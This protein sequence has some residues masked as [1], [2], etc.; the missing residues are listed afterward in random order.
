MKSPHIFPALALL[1][2][3]AACEPGEDGINGYVE[4]EFVRVAP[5]SGGV[6]KTLFVARGD[7][8]AAGDSLF[9]LDLT[10]LEA[11][12]DAAQAEALQAEE[13]WRDLT[14]GSRAEE[15]DVIARQRAQAVAVLENA[16]KQFRR[17][18]ELVKADATSIKQRDQDKAAFESAAARVA[19]LEAQLQVAKLPERTDRVAAA[20]AAADAA[21]AA[22]GRAEKLL[23]EARPRA[24][25]A[26]QVEDTF[27]RPGEFV[28]PGAPVVSLLP[29]GNVKVR[30]FAPQKL[31]PRLRPGRKVTVICDGC[32]APVTAAVSFI[33]N[34]AEF[35]PP[36]IYSVESREKLVFLVEAVPEDFHPELRPGLPVAIA[37][38][39]DAP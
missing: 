11:A 23:E 31:L 6:L 10:L 34:E 12:R 17:S 25:A 28:Q 18:E 38:A 39:E 22:L 2:L 5:S 13:T 24:P 9:S 36:V 26:A 8:V 14:K 16:E 20:R 21:R 32:T 19:E 4:G 35:T 3:L 1:A 37:L 33:A 7:K 29:P 15:I 27:Y 30:F